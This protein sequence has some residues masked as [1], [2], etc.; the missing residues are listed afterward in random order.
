MNPLDNHPGARRTMYYFAF[1][2]GLILG[3]LQV[4]YG[5]AATAQPSWLTVTL[6]VYAFAASYLGLT[7]AKHTPASGAEAPTSRG[8]NP[9]TASGPAVDA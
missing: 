9:A 6:A 5:A 1:A 4:G 8:A 7:A 3:G 2:V